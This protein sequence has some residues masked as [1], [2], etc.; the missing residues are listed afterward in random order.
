MT[1]EANLQY[2]LS[3]LIST[4]STSL[5]NRQTAVRWFNR[6]Y[7]D[8]RRWNESFIKFLRS[9][10][11]FKSQAS[12][13]DYAAFLEMLKQYRD[14]LDERYGNVKDDLCSNL[15]ILS[16]RF[17]KDFGWLYE[18]DQYEFT[19][20]REILDKSYQSELSII[21]TA[22]LICNHIAG[23]YPYEEWDQVDLDWHIKHHDEVVRKVK[24]YEKQANLEVKRLHEMS[25][26]VGV[27]LLSVNE[28][29]AAIKTEGS[30]NPDIMVIG[31]VT[32]ISH[33]TGPVNVKS[34]LNHV[35]QMVN[36]TSSLSNDEK[37]ELERLINKLQGT[38]DSSS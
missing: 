14:S 37:I 19:Q 28:Y 30:Q 26:G 6:L 29:E 2:L 22:R 21:N 38:L 4:T 32:N 25:Q 33:V 8:V 18:Q 36:D 34:T 20:L 9:Y 31:E 15:K 1:P 13:S 3:R 10:P 11:G 23:A 35:A 16:V 7:Y 17:P 12:A 27:R 5:A 24:G